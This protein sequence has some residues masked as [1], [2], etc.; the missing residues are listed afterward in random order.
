ML[1]SSNV[2][3]QLARRPAVAHCQIEIALKIDPRSIQA[4]LDALGLSQPSEDAERAVA[5]A[6]NL[7]K[8]PR[9]QSLPLGQ[10]RDPFARILVRG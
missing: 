10:R 4:D 8:L 7:S 1:R 2:H 6:A 5:F 9:L 3:A